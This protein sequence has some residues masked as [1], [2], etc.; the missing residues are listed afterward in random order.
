MKRSKTQAPGGSRE[1]RV[2]TPQGPGGRSEAR[3]VNAA[4]EAAL[5]FLEADENG[6]GVL[7]WHEFKGAVN[8]LRKNAGT[9]HTLMG[10]K[11]EAT[12]RELFESIDT[13]NSGTIEMDEYFLWTLDVATMHGSGLEAIFKRY[14]SNGEGTLDASEFAM[15]VE[16]M[17]FD[18]LMAHSLFMEL[19]DDGSGA[20][21]CAELVEALKSRPKSV[22]TE[23]K[24]FLTTLAFA[25]AG[26][27]RQAHVGKAGSSKRDSFQDAPKKRGNRVLEMVRAWD[28]TAS[29]PETL[30]KQVHEHLL[31][32]SISATD[33]CELVM[34]G[35]EKE[36]TASVFERVLT[37]KMGLKD[38]AAIARYA[39]LTRK[40]SSP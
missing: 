4:R 5:A 33:W 35:E 10:I 20:V 12:L 37:V 32:S 26:K 7:E 1:A 15:A 2:V 6:D 3:A 13:D 39:S 27:G 21:S 31:K 38:G 40:P 30:R 19:D 28:L 8:R 9:S 16:D 22:S 29:S 14:D 34:M 18:S 23:S 24:K 17:G 36:L 11:D 25:D